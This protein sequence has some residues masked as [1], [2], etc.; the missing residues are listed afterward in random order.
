MNQIQNHES[1]GYIKINESPENRELAQKHIDTL[2][3]IGGKKHIDKYTEMPPFMSQPLLLEY[4]K[5]EG[6]QVN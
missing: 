1:L 3:I 2:D 4:I 5:S 6:N